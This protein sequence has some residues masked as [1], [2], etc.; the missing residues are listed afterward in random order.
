MRRR[1]RSIFGDSL[2]EFC[3]TMDKCNKRIVFNTGIVY[4]RLIIT[5]IIGLLASRYVLLALGASDY[6]LYAVVGGIISMLNVLSV[7]MY[8]TTQRYINVEM[9]NPLGNLNKIF[10][11]SRL[12]HIGFAMFFFLI[13]EIV[14]V[15]YICNYLNVVP[16]KFNDA[17]FIFHIS[18][19]AAV[20]G[21]INVPYQA[22]LQAKEKFAQ[23]AFIDIVSSVVKLLLIVFLFVIKGNVLRIY[24]VGMSM[25]TVLS[26]LF[27]NVACA[28]QWREVIRYKFYRDKKVYKEILVF[29]NY[30][31]LGATSYLS[32][33]Q[34]SNMLVNYFFGTLVNAAFAIGYTIENYC[35]MFI[36]NV[37]SAAAPQITQ[38]YSN[39][40]NRAVFLTEVLNKLTIFLTLI[41]VV[42]IS[43]ELD[44]ILEIWLKNVPDGA[45]LVCHLTLLS[46]LA[47]VAFG[48]MDKL[49]QASGKNKWFQISGSIIQLA[50]IPIGFILFR[51]GLPAYSIIVLYICST[52]IGSAFSFYLMN[53]IL[54][55]DIK[56]YA[57]HVFVPSFRVMCLL[58]LFVLIYMKIN[59]NFVGGHIVG[60]VVGFLVTLMAIYYTGLKASEKDMLKRIVISRIANSKR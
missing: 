11:I 28:I 13:A 10:N 58:V 5:T 44:F 42:P 32:R 12:L 49:V 16:E 9:G 40:N 8:T 34:A 29:N 47:R 22:L 19:I 48:G 39:N 33:T 31:A 36:S 15:Y 20:V 25:L 45:L 54:H 24:A 57:K 35:M 60:M 18:T 51:I 38:N 14:G 1:H 37:G 56:Q 50:V 27:Y 17:L 52:I 2:F 21:I 3:Y 59:L 6:G 55:F 4:A 7:A 30:V 46:T 43:I 26:L 23:I 53:K 41:V